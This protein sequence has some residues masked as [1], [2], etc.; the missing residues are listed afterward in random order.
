MKALTMLFLILLVALPMVVLARPTEFE[1]ARVINYFENRDP[2]DFEVKESNDYYPY[3][4]DIQSQPE[5]PSSYAPEWG[6]DRLVSD[7][8]NMG[9]SVIS[10][11][12]DNSNYLYVMGLS[13]NSDRDTLK[14]FKSVDQGYTWSLIWQYGTASD[15]QI[16]DFEMRVNHTGSDPMI[17]FFMIDT[18]NTQRSLWIGKITQPAMTHTWTKF[19]PDTFVGF[20]NPVRLSMDITDGATPSIWCTYEK[21]IGTTDYGWYSI[22]S[23]DG[24]TNWNVINHALTRGARDP[25]VSFGTDYVYVVTVYTAS[26]DNNALRMYSAPGDNSGSYFWVSDNILADRSYP[27]VASTR[28]VFSGNSVNVLYQEG[29]STNSRIRESFSTDGGQN[30][31]LAQ[32]WPMTGDV[33]SVKP[34]VRSGWRGGTS[35]EFCGVATIVA[36]FDSLVVAYNTTGSSWGSRTVPNDHD[37]TGEVTPQGTVISTG[38]AVVYREWGS[39]NVWFESFDNT[40]VEESPSQALPVWNICS[41]NGRITVNFS[42]TSPQQV[43]LRIYDVTGR[44]VFSRDM[45]MISDG[46]HSTEISSQ[47]LSGGR[48][49]VSLITG[50]S[51]YSKSA[52]LF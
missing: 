21:T 13:N 36:S 10:F 23:T 48:Y 18:F 17:Y 42:I 30:W 3:L 33:Q 28:E 12:Y 43:T 25:Y 32:L 14:L 44:T 37:A 15:W 49:F 16:K 11:D 2:L 39:S 52:I 4:D 34:Y 6:T 9:G 38:R 1:H 41:L 46:T 47:G 29:T 20:E 35:D 27:C 40:A 22:Y 51:Q 8:W 7:Q 19:S 5:L 24:G 26:G 31:T 45:G 50:E